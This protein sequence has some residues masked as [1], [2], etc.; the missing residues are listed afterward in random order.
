MAVAVGCWLFALQRH[1]N[2]TSTAL[3]RHFKKIGIGA[4]IRIAR[5]SQCLPYTG[6]FRF[7]ENQFYNKSHNDLWTRNRFLMNISF[8]FLKERTTINASVCICFALTDCVSPS[9]TT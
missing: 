3:P 7:F 5:E 4:S 9:S 2:G 1:F 8:I 6:F